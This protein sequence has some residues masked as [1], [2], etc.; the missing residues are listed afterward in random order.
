MTTEHWQQI[1]SLFHAALERDAGERSVFL[2]QSCNGD[3][4][5]RNE[6]EQLLAAF[7][8]SGDFLGSTALATAAKKISADHSQSPNGQTFGHYRIDQF[9][10]SGGMGEVFAA[11]D[12]RM[13]RKVAL[14]LLPDYFM[15]DRERIA[16][17]EQESKAVLA[18]NHPNIVTV[19]EV[20][21]ENGAHF[22]ANEFIEGETL[23]SRLK[24]APLTVAEALDVA[25]QMGSAL[26]AA[27]QSAIVHRDIKPENIML[28]PDGYVKVLDFGI[29]KL[30]DAPGIT[31]DFSERQQDDGKPTGSSGASLS[32]PAGTVRYMSPEQL[33]GMPIDARADI[34]SLGVVLYEMLA[35]QRPFDASSSKE[36]IA[37]IL[38][39]EPAP[40]SKKEIP[41]E[42]NWITR[43]ALRKDRD[44]RYQTIKEMLSDLREVRQDLEVRARLNL[45]PNGFQP[46]PISGRG[47]ARNRFINSVTNHRWIAASVVLLAVGLALAG[48]RYYPAQPRTIS[49]LAVLPFINIGGN[50]GSDYLSDGVTEAL[51]NDLS[52]L[53]DVKVIAANSMSRYKVHDSQSTLPDPQK[54]AHELGVQAILIGKIVQNGDDLSVSAELVN[55]DDNSHIWGAQYERKLS[56]IFT[57]QADIAKDISNELRTTLT[58]STKSEFA[59]RHTENLKAFEYYMQG[60]SYIHRRTREDLMLAGS[61]YQKAIEQDPNYALAYT[62]LAE[63]YGN[64][65]VRGYIPPIE[66]RQK[67]EEA[68]RK[69]VAL[70]DNLAEAHVMMGYYYMGY[71]PYDFANGDRELH[72]AIELSPSLAI[73]HLYLAL[74]LLR[75]GRLDEGGNEML[76]ARDLDPFSAIIARQVA[77][78]YHFK[79]DYA[80]AL[81]VLRQSNELGPLFTTTNE[82][83]IYI[84]NKLYDEALKGLDDE[85]RTRKED[86]LLIYSRAMVYAAQGRRAEA[87]A[88]AKELAAMSANASQA[89]WIAKIYAALNDK[90]QAFAWLDRGL[91][92][93]TLAVFYG[94]EPTWDPL[95]NDSR[96]RDLL[97]RIGIPQS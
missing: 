28:R 11:T 88:I 65:G 27:H 56:A 33:R 51:I 34:W 87:A 92:T 60:R 23:R 66:G 54:V 81:Q 12:T 35:G 39:N 84:Q 16:R 62:G 29:A 72:R 10:G 67:L 78:Y 7:E 89:Q 17:F 70:D 52:Q 61:Y 41:A 31:G 53:P 93:G 38:D 32:T 57:V 26:S 15:N 74:S 4:S 40:L 96:W 49:S 36:T 77:L 47:F 8:N 21:E 45:K 91:D 13:N 75:Q 63:V 80:R 95:R 85:S 68:A 46:S 58:P 6:V 30:S 44:E 83:G 79:R 94:A 59:K 22:I 37:A 55:A 90:D 71:A 82:V 69:A 43:K 76:K 48:T 3:G 97:R 42:L 86:P 50:P 73:A 25:I 5:I 2:A 19:Y 14:K 64:L 20:G 9:V 1:E 18:L 24:R